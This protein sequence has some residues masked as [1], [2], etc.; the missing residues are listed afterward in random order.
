MKFGIGFTQGTAEVSSSLLVYADLLALLDLLH[1]Y[2][3]CCVV[4]VFTLYRIL[5]RTSRSGT[6]P[7]PEHGCRRKPAPMR[8]TCIIYVFMLL[9]K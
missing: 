7:Y 6:L 1:A 8:S 4:T 9:Q 3:M 2:N 5:N